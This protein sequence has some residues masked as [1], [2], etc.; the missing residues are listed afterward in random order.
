M[1]RRLPRLPPLRRGRCHRP[2]RHRPARP[3][4][5]SRR[6]PSPSRPFRLGAG[7][8]RSRRRPAARPPPGRSFR[9]RR[10]AC[11]RHLRRRRIP[12]AWACWNRCSRRP[13]LP[14]PRLPRPRLLLPRPRCRLLR[15]ALSRRCPRRRPGLNRRPGLKSVPS[16]PCRSPGLSRLR[17]RPG[18]SHRG[19]SSPGGTSLPL[20]SHP[21]PQP[22]RRHPYLPSPAL[23]GR[24]WLP[25]IA[26][27]TKG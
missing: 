22:R 12:G 3:N 24:Y 23:P 6:F 7:R 1:R 26:S 11:Q 9:P 16:P 2:V 27:T 5:C 20:P 13:R 8:S 25:W 10:P 19:R 18:L 15:P 17:L 4:R 14:R 21:P